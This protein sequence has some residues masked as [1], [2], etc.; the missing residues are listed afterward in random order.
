M[1]LQ[2][3]RRL[4]RNSLRQ[5]DD[6]LARRLGGQIHVA[7][8]SSGAPLV[9]EARLDRPPRVAHAWLDQTIQYAQRVHRFVL[10]PHLDDRCRVDATIPVKYRHVPADDAMMPQRLCEHRA[11]QPR[12]Q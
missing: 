10:A 11:R 9:R 12:E 1:V 7:R 2:R 6:R 5:R 4:R 3:I 8:R